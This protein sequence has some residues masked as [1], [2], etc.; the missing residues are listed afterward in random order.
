MSRSQQQL[1]GEVDT[2][3]ILGDY[4]GNHCVL[5]VVLS[6]IYLYCGL[7]EPPE[8]PD[9][10]IYMK[11]D[12]SD[13]RIYIPKFDNDER[14]LGFKNSGGVS[15]SST[16]EG[17]IST[18]TPQYAAEY[19]S[20]HRELSLIKLSNG[21]LTITCPPSNDINLH[22]GTMAPI[23]LEVIANLIN[24]KNGNKYDAITLD[25]NRID[26]ERYYKQWRERIRPC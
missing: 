17:I 10:H 20:N 9:G 2:T 1:P 7:G 18:S 11:L 25:C 21:T 15:L 23:L 8:N 3:T 16:L 24:K 26:F 22:S 6:S 5:Y 12:E 13:Q 14:F 19:I 4:Q